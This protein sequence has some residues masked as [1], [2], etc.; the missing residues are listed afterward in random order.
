MIAVLREKVTRLGMPAALVVTDGNL[1]WPAD[2]ASISVVF[3]VRALHHL[4]AGH[5]LGSYAAFSAPKEAG[6]P[7]APS[8]AEQLGEFHDAAPDAAPRGRGRLQRPQSRGPDR[9]GVRGSGGRERQARR[10]TYVAQ[11]T[12]M[13]RP[14]D[15]LD[16]WA[17]KQGLADSRS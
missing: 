11:W 7:S 3:S 17:G 4:E 9:N 6:W 2:D 13:H 12:R 5:V 10:A 8:P 14:V 16:S 1:R 15:S